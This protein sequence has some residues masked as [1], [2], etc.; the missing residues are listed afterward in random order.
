MTKNILIA[1]VLGITI[2]IVGTLGYAL[3]EGWSLLDSLYMTVIT[4][5]TIGYGEIKPLHDQ[6]RIFTI[7]LIVFGVGNMAYLIGQLTRL[8]VEGSLKQVLG[9]R[10]L[11]AQIKK[12]KDHYI[13]CGYGRI[14]RTVARL[15]TARNVPLIVLEHKTEVIEQLEKDGMLF[16]KGDASD[17]DNMLAAGIKNAKGLISAVSSDADNLFIVLTARDLNPNLFILT[18][19]S[20]EKSTKK[21]MGAGANR[22]I[23]PYFIGARK[24]AETVLRPAVSDFLETTVHGMSG[25]DLAMEEI[26][27]TEESRIKNVT[28]MESN[29]R[30]DLDIIIIAIKKPDGR[31]LFNPSAQAMIRQ[32]DTLI[33]VGQR[34]NMERLIFLLGAEKF[35]PP[36]T[37]PGKQ[38]DY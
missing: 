22:V 35:T 29:I 19:A 31:M 26:L 38:K 7:F 6:G 33:S 4:L 12:L 24:M 34:E 14:G 28:L 36:V 9:R 21:L 8:M 16:I 30:R 18:R 2:V 15:I 1:S 17:E 27:V 23:S 32:G 20:Q 13:L 10:M 37:T 5:A 11:E 3:I 25:L